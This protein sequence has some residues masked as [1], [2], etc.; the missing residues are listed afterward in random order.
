MLTQKNQEVFTIKKLYLITISIRKVI[1]VSTLILFILALILICFNFCLHGNI[2]SWLFPTTSGRF[3]F[4]SSESLDEAYLAIIIDDLGSG[5]GGVKE[6]MSINKHITFAVMPFCE[7]SQEDAQ[8]AHE[9]GYEVIVHLPMEANTGKRSWLGPNPILAGMGSEKVKRIVWDAFD[10]VP[11]A[12]GANIHMGSKASSEESIV[13]AI[14]DVI[15][16]KNVYFVDSRTAYH[17]VA[18][19][20]ADEKGILC[21]ERDTFIDGQQ[22]KSFIKK[23][24]N[25]ACEV[26]RKKGYAI[27]IGH[28]GIEGGKATAEAIYEMLPVF[29]HKNIRL[30]FV[31]EL[32]K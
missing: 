1:Y 13:T 3:N 12:V 11:F 10:S 14:L 31:S 21:Y 19:R 25:E 23:R 28:V 20:I 6:L 16:E 32:P 5:R 4:E 24:L 15:K 7:F 22:S 30:V 2:S 8:N 9:K 18:K 27:A 29:D 26:A 17:P